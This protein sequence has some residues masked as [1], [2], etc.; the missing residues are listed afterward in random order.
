MLPIQQRDRVNL[1]RKH[2]KLLAGASILLILLSGRLAWPRP[3]WAQAAAPG[4]REPAAGDTLSGTVV[5]RGTADDPAYLRYE[6]AFRPESGSDAD[7]IV[8]AEGDQPVRD[9]TL[10]VWDTTVGRSAGAPVWPDGRYRLRLRVVRTDYN[11]SEYFVTDLAIRNDGTP[12]PTPTITATVTAGAPG[13]AQTPAFTVLT[14]IPSLT[15]FPTVTP[16]PTAERPSAGAAG[17]TPVSPDD[18]GGLLGQLAQAETSRLTAAFW[19][20]VRLTGWLFAALLLYL[21]LRAAGRWL[22]RRA[23]GARRSE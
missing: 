3:L 21:L 8:F 7:W 1:K 23:W 5:V 16:L 6:L 19:L 17:E 14:P 18:P 15:P 10:A 4:I 22:W 9:G 11:Y 2:G 12:T 13:A 20:G